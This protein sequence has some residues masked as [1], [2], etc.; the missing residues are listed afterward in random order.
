M[1]VPDTHVI[2]AFNSHRARGKSGVAHLPGCTAVYSFRRAAH[3]GYYCIPIELLPRI[4]AVCG[5]GV[6]VLRKPYDDIMKCWG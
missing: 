5:S 1:I 4:K 6:R 2:V 3:G